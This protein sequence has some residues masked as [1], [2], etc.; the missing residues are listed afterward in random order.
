MTFTPTFDLKADKIL[1]TNYFA[2]LLAMMLDQQIPLER[3]FMG[4]Y[5]LEQRLNRKITPKLLNGIDTLELIDAFCQSPSLHR[6]PKS[7]AERAKALSETIVRDFNSNVELIWDPKLPA[8]QVIKNL[9]SL[10]GFGEQKAKIFLAL[11][12]KQFDIKPVG[13][14]KASEPYGKKQVYLSVADIDS[15]LA[16]SKVKETKKAMKLAKL[17]PGGAL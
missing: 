8:D 12:A 4:P 13:W 16:Y 1:N 15:K 6:F 14:E 11:L 2:L 3:A 7:M 5:L 10:P 9:K 17:N